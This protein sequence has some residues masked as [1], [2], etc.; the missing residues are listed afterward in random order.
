MILKSKG[1]IM[2]RTESAVPMTS[3]AGL[4]RCGKVMEEMEKRLSG[5]RPD[6]HQHQVLLSLMLIQEKVESL[7]E[8]E[9]AR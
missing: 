5:R 7:H 4:K 3:T 9:E 2:E 6:S 8:E 1:R